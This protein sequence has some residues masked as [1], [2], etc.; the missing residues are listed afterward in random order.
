[1]LFEEKIQE[2]GV[3]YWQGHTRHYVRALM[4]NEN[5][6][7]NVC[8]MCKVMKVNESGTMFCE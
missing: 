6:L 3:E 5:N 8:K 7:T 2:N 1:M 4:K